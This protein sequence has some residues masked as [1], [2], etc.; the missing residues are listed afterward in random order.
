MTLTANKTVKAVKPIEPALDDAPECVLPVVLI[1][2]LSF[3]EFTVRLEWG[4][5]NNETR[6]NTN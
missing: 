6:F 4:D 3:H 2:W 1:G 5:D